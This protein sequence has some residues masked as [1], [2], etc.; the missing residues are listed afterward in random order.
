M[1]VD[2]GVLSNGTLVKLEV[3]ELIDTTVALLSLLVT[4]ILLHVTGAFIDTAGL[5]FDLIIGKLTV[6]PDDNT[7]DTIGAFL[8]IVGV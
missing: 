3:Q 8:D 2:N 5:L 4:V 1:F 7:V 6:L